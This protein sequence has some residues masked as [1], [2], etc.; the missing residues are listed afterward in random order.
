MAPIIISTDSESSQYY[1]VD[2]FPYNICSRK[3]NEIHEFEKDVSHCGRMVRG[4]ENAI[5]DE[6]LSC[7]K[8]WDFIEDVV[9]QWNFPPIGPLENFYDSIQFSKALEDS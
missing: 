1:E 5:E 4:T 7:L 8:I 9:N 6:W 3:N 2:A